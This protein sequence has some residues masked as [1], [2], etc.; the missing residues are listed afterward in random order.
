M[1]NQCSATTNSRKEMVHGTIHDCTRKWNTSIR[2]DFYR[3][4]RK[5]KLSHSAEKVKIILLFRY[6]IFTSFWAYKVRTKSN[7]QMND[8]FLQNRVFVDLLC[9]RIYVISIHNS[10]HCHCL[11]NNSGDVFSAQC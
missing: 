8:F 1:S 7:R 11:C 2:F 5:K 10:R 3:N 4:V 9:L 6:F